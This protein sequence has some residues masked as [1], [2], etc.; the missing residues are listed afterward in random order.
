[1]SRPADPR[2]APDFKPGFYPSCDGSPAPDPDTSHPVECRM[3]EFASAYYRLNCGY[4]E[5]RLA[6]TGESQGNPEN[7]LQEIEQAVHARDALEDRLAPEGFYAEPVLD[8]I[9]TVNL[10]FSHALKKTPKP[11]PPAADS[12]FSLYVPMPPPGTDME[13]YLRR[14]L[15]GVFGH[16]DNPGTEAHSQRHP[17]GKKRSK[18]SP[19]RKSHAEKTSNSMSAG[20]ISA[21]PESFPSRTREAPGRA[22]KSPKARPRKK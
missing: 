21:K 7:L 9:L 22:I 4:E 18:P 14:Y 19:G 8:G 17:A 2:F 10:V 16:S 15:G 1:M 12:T 20:K 5:L 11:A 13:A 6:R 3:L